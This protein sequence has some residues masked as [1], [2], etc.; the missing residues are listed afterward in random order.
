MVFRLLQVPGRHIRSLAKKKKM[1]CNIV[2]CKNVVQ[3]VCKSL[4]VAGMAEVIWSSSL[5]KT[6]LKTW[7]SVSSGI[8]LGCWFYLSII[9]HVAELNKYHIFHTLCIPIINTADQSVKGLIGR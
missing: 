5:F 3:I 1:W 7:M 6:K 2:Q 4:S 8:C 9:N